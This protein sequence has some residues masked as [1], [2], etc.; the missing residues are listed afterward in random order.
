M[1]VRVI[2]VSADQ[3]KIKFTVQKRSCTFL[4]ASIQNEFKTLKWEKRLSHL[5]GKVKP[6]QNNK[7]NKQ[8]NPNPLMLNGTEM[9]TFIML[10]VCLK[11]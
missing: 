7:E 4:S 2:S 10:F 9:T 5:R 6:K 1:L 3:K 11:D 8:K